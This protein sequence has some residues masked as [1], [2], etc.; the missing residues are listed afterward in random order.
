MFTDVLI[1]D[2]LL[3]IQFFILPK[4]TYVYQNF[5][6][7][8]ALLILNSTNPDSVVSQWDSYLTYE[9]SV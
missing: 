5:L 1:F 4:L 6:K 2:Q 3:T 7:T 9:N 8:I